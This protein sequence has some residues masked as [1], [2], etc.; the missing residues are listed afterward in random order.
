MELG[1]RV[2]RES[3]LPGLAE[4][5]RVVDW[6]ESELNK[7]SNVEIFYDSL[8]DAEQ[9]KEFGADCVALAT[10]SLWRRDGTGRWNSSPIAGSDRANVYTPE[11]VMAG[12][13]PA[14]PVVV[15]DDDHYYMGGVI[16]E[17]LRLE[18]HEVTLVTTS[19]EASSWTHKT[20]EHA[21]VQARLLE[22][23]V[24]IETGTSLDEVLDGH[25][26][27]ACAFSEE[28]RRIEANS[29]VMVTSRQPTDALYDELSGEINITRIGDC[30]APGLIAAAV[31]S[32]HRYAREF[33]NQ[34]KG[35][36][37]FRRERIALP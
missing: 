9:I 35:D 8:L 20:N 17:K 36:V 15:F 24:R 4:W 16:A 26:E 28:S 19:G 10:G 34:P 14:G 32:G 33:D 30:D 13:L 5:L 6:R 29:V 7:L 22:V 12:A 1:G 23:G 2:A 21:R 31:F 25:V 18:G 3:K 11:D 27:L 37:P